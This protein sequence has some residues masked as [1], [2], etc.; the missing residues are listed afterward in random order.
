MSLEDVRTGEYSR[1]QTETSSV[2]LHA[3]RSETSGSYTLDKVTDRGNSWSRTGNASI[4]AY[5]LERESDETS[6]AIET[7][8]HGAYSASFT[9]ILSTVTSLDES[10]SE[11]SG[12]YD[13]HEQGDTSANFVQTN[14]IAA[15]TVFVTESAHGTFDRSRLGNSSTGGYSLNESADSTYSATQSVSGSV[16]RPSDWAQKVAWRVGLR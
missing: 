4:G 2:S 13:R 11:F 10:G 8:F 7:N 16:L 3:E 9:E 6:T 12:D 5:H 1:T 15:G 14:T